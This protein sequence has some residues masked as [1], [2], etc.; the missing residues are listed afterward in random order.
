MWK[1][2]ETAPKDGT[3]IL[4]CSSTHPIAETWWTDIFGNGRWGG[5][6]WYYAAWLPPTHWMSLPEKPEFELEKNES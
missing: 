6:G 5:N 1:T 3:H 2:M 4:T